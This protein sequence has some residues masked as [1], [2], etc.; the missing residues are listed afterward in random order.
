M[1]TVLECLESGTKYLEGRGIEDA[2]RNMQWMVG[3]VL[4]CDRMK[5]YTEFD[6]PLSDE[7]LTPLREM[8]KQ[9][10]QG[11]P[12][13]H[14]LGTVPFLGRD[15]LCD[16]R[17]LVPRP[18]T[19]ELADLVKGLPF[20]RPTRVLDV[21][22]GSGVLGI[23]L[24]L[25]LAD[26]CQECVLVDLSTE[27]LSLAKENAALHKLEVSLLESDLLTA[28][29]GQFGLILANL[30]YVPEGERSEISREVSHDPASALFSGVDGLDHLRR[31]LAEVPAFLSP[32]GLLA[33]EI[34]HDQAERVLALLAETPLEAC[35]SKKDLSGISRFIFARAPM[36]A[37][38]SPTPAPVTH[39]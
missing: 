6:R 9:R 27:A 16:Q 13:Q 28:V 8:L 35:E 22:T 24:A 5:L 36:A 7:E 37:H 14:L 29:S 31:F 3:H 11:V 38:D 30:P 25:E 33:L 10:G 15:F 34:G 2:R 21:G 4:E 1:K 32:G 39:G 18:E 12:L 26:D 23:S 20:P 17:G 19:E